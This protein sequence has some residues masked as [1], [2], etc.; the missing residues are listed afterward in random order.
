M[1]QGDSTTDIIQHA[2]VAGELAKNL[3]GRSDFEKYD[4]AWAEL[5][6]WFVDYR[7]GLY[8][9]PGFEFC[10]YIEWTPGQNV[11]FFPFQFS[12]D[13]A[14][15]YLLIFTDSKVRF[16]QDG[17]YV[18][19]AAKSVTSVANGIG[20]RLTLTSAAHGFA[21]G[22]L[23]K[24]SGFTQA[25][26]TFLN[27]RTVKV[28]NVTTNTFD[29]QDAITGSL[30]SKA[31][32]TGTGSASRVYTVASPYTS[33]D[34]YALHGK[35]I[36]DVFRM[37]HPDYP[38]KNLTRSAHTSWAIANETIGANISRPGSGSSTSSASNNWKYVYAVTAV[39]DAGEE[40]LPRLIV[41]TAGDNIVSAADSWNS[42]S[43]PNV[44]AAIYYRVYRSRGGKL[45]TSSFLTDST[46]GARTA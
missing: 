34:L 40:S 20:N 18:L 44:S 15:G 7:G 8:T 14:N 2:S 13:T 33:D 39:D 4:S 21:N 22:D 9:R 32:S 45:S 37:T 6:N 19:E 42:I 12:P 1:P 3:W 38:I 46:L 28:A 31:I 27:T 29:L 26:L 43:W 25:T 10:D 23:V 30:I 5:I 35:Q 41:V 36:S 16:A 11:R 17:A 24:L